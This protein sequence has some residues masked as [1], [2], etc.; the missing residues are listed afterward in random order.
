MR[1][2]A[3]LLSY[4]ARTLDRWSGRALALL[5]QQP[6]DLVRYDC[7]NAMRDWSKTSRP[8]WPS[9]LAIVNA[10]NRFGPSSMIAPWQAAAPPRSASRT[11]TMVCWSLQAPG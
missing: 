4:T 6:P 11:A 8:S 5:V 2:L 1:R 3:S 9:C 7:L 10:S